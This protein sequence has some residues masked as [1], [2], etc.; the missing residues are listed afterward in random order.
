MD[1]VEK[2][3]NYWLKAVLFSV[4]GIISLSLLSFAAPSK[5]MHEE[6]RDNVASLQREGE[7]GSRISVQHGLIAAKQNLSGNFNWGDASEACGRLEE[8]G[9]NDWR[10]PNKDEL[11]KLYLSR[12]LIGGFSDQRYWSSTEYDQNSAL[13]QQFLDGFQKLIPKVDSLYVRPVR[14]F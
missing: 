4:L 11:N 6:A 7:P 13:S 12:S 9:Y 10:L 1:G 14:I 8:N 5:K 2:K 3:C